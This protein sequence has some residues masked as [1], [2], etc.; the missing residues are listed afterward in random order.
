MPILE[1]RIS[2]LSQDSIELSR[3]HLAPTEC[4]VTSSTW[5]MPLP[6]WYSMLTASC[7][8]RT[9]ITAL[10]RRNSWD[11]QPCGPTSG[12]ASGGMPCNWRLI[13]ANS[14]GARRRSRSSKPSHGGDSDPSRAC[15]SV[16]K[17]MAGSSVVASAARAGSVTG[18]ADPSQRRR[19]P[20]VLN[21][22]AIRFPFQPVTD[23]L[24]D[25][26]IHRLPR[27]RLIAL[28]CG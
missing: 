15:Q 16:L 21:G 26:G 17:P 28:Q 14:S 19:D 27:L 23:V 10:L 9:V 8:S 20:F 4:R 12:K 2:D 5:M 6:S 7:F 3:P 13:S 11:G 25:A 1:L 24:D 18:F 22:L